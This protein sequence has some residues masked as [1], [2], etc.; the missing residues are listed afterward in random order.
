MNKPVNLKPP[1]RYV[2]VA[3]GGFFLSPVVEQPHCNFVL[4][5]MWQI[6]MNVLKKS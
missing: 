3:G 6:Q 4:Q 5:E 1:Q 2:L